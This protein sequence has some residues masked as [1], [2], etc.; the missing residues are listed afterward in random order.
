M[1][2]KPTAM[3]HRYNNNHFHG[4]CHDYYQSGC[5][6]GQRGSMSMTSMQGGYQQQGMTQQQQGGYSTTM[7]QPTMVQPPATVVNVQPNMVN[8]QPPD[9]GS[10]LRAASNTS[11]NSATK[12]KPS[13]G[14]SSEPKVCSGLPERSRLPPVA[15]L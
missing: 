6:G 10:A 4:G 5:G 2:A 13:L 7:A 14:P 8:V 11:H 1:G 3:C 9:D 15:Q 12:S